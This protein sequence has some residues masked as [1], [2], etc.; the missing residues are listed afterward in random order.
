MWGAG[1]KS[2]WWGR[3][4]DGPGQLLSKFSG[5]P[6]NVLVNP[7]GISTSDKGDIFHCPLDFT[8]GAVRAQE[9]SEVPGPNNQNTGLFLDLFDF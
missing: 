6:G 4:T 9:A 3:G 5:L 8:A 7:A 1:S 2:G